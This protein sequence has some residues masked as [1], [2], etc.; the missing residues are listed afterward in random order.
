MDGA[1]VA[2]RDTRPLRNANWPGSEGTASDCRSG[3]DRSADPRGGAVYFS[4][5]TRS[6]PC[7]DRERSVG[8][9]PRGGRLNCPRL[10]RRQ[11][12]SAFSAN[13][14]AITQNHRSA[15]HVTNR[16]GSASEPA[17]DGKKDRGIGKDNCSARLWRSTGDF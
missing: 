16:G 4:A 2:A 7:T 5:T 11:L 9:H 8:N 3:K 12:T 6:P 10:S 1:L 14:P 15:F 17:S 13:R